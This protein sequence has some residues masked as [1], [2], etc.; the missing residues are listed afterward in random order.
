MGRTKHPQG[1]STDA[2]A[3][4][5]SSLGSGFSSPWKPQQHLD[6]ISNLGPEPHS[7]APQFLPLQS[8][9]REDWSSSLF[10][11]SM[12]QSNLLLGSR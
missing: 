1:S 5:G 10:E 12:I 3:L 6:H 11:V 8:L 9:E 2:P 7:K 4:Q